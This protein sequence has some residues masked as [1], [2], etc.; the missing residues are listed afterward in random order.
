[1]RGKQAPKRNISPDPKFNSPLVGKLVN[2][3]MRKGK[4]TIAQKVVYQ[5]FDI[6]QKE[7]KED[8]LSV[9]EKAIENVGPTVEIRARRVG[10]AH[11]QIPF[12]VRGDRR[13]TLALRWIIQAARG[14][15]GRP[16][17]EKLA[18]EIVDASKGE[19]AAMKKKSDV[20]KMAEANKAFAH[21]AKYG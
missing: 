20:H 1:M 14:R 10:G 18:A 12:P 2:H 13:I 9:F 15:K 8:P 17:R 5:A 19:G 21:F 3:V 7:T 11:Y 4:K 16:M 6:I